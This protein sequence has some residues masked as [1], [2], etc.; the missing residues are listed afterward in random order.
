MLSDI[1]RYLTAAR[2]V[3]DVHRVLEIE[4]LDEFGNVGGVGVHIVA[5]H[6]LSGTPVPAAVMGDYAVAMP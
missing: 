3:T 4:R 2:G 5:A 6:S 1:A